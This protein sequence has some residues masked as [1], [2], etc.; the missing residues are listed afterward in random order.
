MT[1]QLILGSSS[2][3]RAQLLSRF[4]IAF[5]TC[6]PDVDESPLPNETPSDLAKR[7]AKSKAMHVAK[8][9]PLAC[10]IGSDQVAEL[11]GSS[12]GKP[13]HFEN[14]VQQLSDC[15]G[16]S[17]NFI[18]SVCVTYR[19][20]CI[21]FSDLTRVI[22]R[23]LNRLEIERYLHAERPYD[24][25]GSFKCE[26]LGISLFERIESNDPTALIGLP[27]IALSKALRDAGF[28]LP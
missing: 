17:V 1:P 9:N 23:S 2:A 11:N 24:C 14:A 22:F 19:D 28:T 6:K 25:A 26:G 13:G 20:Q 3:Y 4:G 12:L 8:L 5:E 27:L 15:S 21:E 18:T 16:Q 7:L 10:V